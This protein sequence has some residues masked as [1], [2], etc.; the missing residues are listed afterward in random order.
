MGV[1]GQIK[2]RLKRQKNWDSKKDHQTVLGARPHIKKNGWGAVRVRKNRRSNC[3]REGCVG[4][5]IRG[6]KVEGGVAEKGTKK[7]RWDNVG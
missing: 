7:T 1:P 5:K 6:G 4:K 2:G 3:I